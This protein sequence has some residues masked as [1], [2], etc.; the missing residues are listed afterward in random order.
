[1]GGEAKIRVIVNRGN[2]YSKRVKSICKKHWRN[3]N[4]TRQH[5]REKGKWF[6]RSCRIW[7]YLLLKFWTYINDE[8]VVWPNV[9]PVSPISHPHSFLFY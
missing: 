3:R 7:V 9:L 2:D 8:V 6:S 4:Y 5:A 1:M